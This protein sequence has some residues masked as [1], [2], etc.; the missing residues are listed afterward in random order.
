MRVESELRSAELH[1]TRVAF[2]TLHR[3]IYSCL[4]LFC[5]LLV[6]DQC[7]LRWIE[8]IALS[9][10]WSC[11]CCLPGPAKAER[12]HGTQPSPKYERVLVTGWCWG[13]TKTCQ[14]L[15][16]LLLTSACRRT[17]DLQVQFLTWLWPDG[18]WKEFLIKRPALLESCKEL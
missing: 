3:G 1:H 7:K 6:L 14:F 13:W 16:R 5:S 12:K 17:E 11:Q 9:P 18:F 2:G 15:L 10:G 8:A 4:A